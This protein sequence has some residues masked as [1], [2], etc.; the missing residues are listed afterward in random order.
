MFHILSLNR[1]E[2]GQSIVEVSVGL[3]F[4]LLLVIIM[5][6]GGIMFSTYMALIDAARDGARY[7]SERPWLDPNDPAPERIEAYKKYEGIIRTTASSSGL[8]DPTKLII[9]PPEIVDNAPPE[10]DE[11]VVRVTYRVETFTSSITLPFFGRMGLPYYWPLT[12]EARWPI[13]G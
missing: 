4:L 2:K 8:T 12:Y 6:E 11:I 9:Y 3:V 13:K 5:F 10:H 7:A 1:D